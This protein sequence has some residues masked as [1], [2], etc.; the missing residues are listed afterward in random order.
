M[1]SCTLVQHSSPPLGFEDWV[2]NTLTNPIIKNTGRGQNVYADC[3]FCAKTHN[4]FSVNLDTG[5]YKCYIC[6]DGNGRNGGNYVSLV[7]RLA[8]VSFDK[9]DDFLLNYGRSTS[10]WDIERSV[11]L[12]EI[13]TRPRYDTLPDTV[14]LFSGSAE[15][16]E[17]LQYLKGRG[18][19]VSKIRNLQFKVAV[20]GHYEGRIMM[21]IIENGEVV[22]FIAR[23][24]L[25]RK[26]ALRYTGPTL[27]DGWLP[28][29]E[30]LFNL[31]SV[32]RGEEAILVEGVLDSLSIT[33]PSPVVALL[34]KS[35]SPTQ[36]SKLLRKK[37]GKITVL[38]DGS[39]EKE[40]FKTTTYAVQKIA[41]QFYGFIPEI[42]YA[43]MPALRDPNNSPEMANLILE[44]AKEYH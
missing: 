39:D 8:R 6:G 25:T 18:I 1:K 41:S 36:L 16:L 17:A 12:P 5:M 14:G 11:Q 44:N 40:Y 43:T 3:P 20:A 19:N 31:D 24:Y 15:A 10:L 23:D 13:N 30:C 38:L 9:V 26:N 42:R 37:L 33:S 27:T 35:L 28:K 7:G 4:H 22:N 21:P 2:L 34:G 32:V 29:S